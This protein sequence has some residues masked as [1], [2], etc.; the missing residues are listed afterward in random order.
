M[1]ATA[2]QVLEPIFSKAFDVDP[3]RNFPA[4]KHVQ[5]T[6]NHIKEMN[7]PQKTLESKI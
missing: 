7:Y 6:I 2:R 1:F 5:R 3:E 4:L